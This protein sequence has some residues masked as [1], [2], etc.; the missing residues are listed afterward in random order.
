MN[1]GRRLLQAALLGL[2]ALAVQAQ[3]RA[4][5]PELLHPEGATAASDKP[6]APASAHAQHQMVAAAHPLAAAAGLQILRAGGSAL[7][8][9]V[10]TQLVLT[11]VEP[12]SSGIGG[13]AFLL[14]HDGQQTWAYDGRETAPAAAGEQLFL[15]AQGRPLD[16]ADAAVGGRAVGTPGVLRMLAL[17]HQRHGRL[18]WARL[19]GPA[20]ELAEQGFAM[21]PRLHALL[22]QTPQLRLDPH[23]AALYFD[24]QGQPLPV[25]TVLRNPELA[26][27]LRR[28]AAEGPDAFY[29]G[30]IAAA[31]VR[32]VREHPRNPG[33]LSLDDL[34]RYQAVERAPLCFEHRTASSSSD[35]GPPHAYRICGMPPPSSGTIAVGQILGLLQQARATTAAAAAGAREPD[36]PAALHLYAEASRLAFADRARYLAD[37]DHVALPGPQGQALLEPSYLARRAR[38]IDVQR[39]LPSAP[40]GDPTAAPQAL[41]PMP[42]QPE[43]GTSH[44]SIADRHGHVLAMTSSIEAAFGSRLMVNRGLG[45][46]GG[47]LL[48]NQ[49]TDFSFS[50]RD[51]NGQVVA[52]RVQ[53]NK[54]P[55]SSMTPVL[56][57]E[58]GSGRP[59]LSAG[60]PGGAYIIHYV[61]RLLLGVLDQGLPVAQAIA[62]PHVAAFD[63][64]VVLEQGRWPAATAQALRTLGHA[65]REQALP[66]GLQAIEIGPGWLRG[67][68]DPRREGLAL[69][70]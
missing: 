24:A 10:A 37:P 15:D 54:R 41:A 22:R 58:T 39:R 38:L 66:S 20:I 62:Q 17:A 32:A 61:S 36:T 34:R 13:G 6:P 40:A 33:L 25:G 29:G 45:L 28:I 55:R 9:A 5:L 14:Y 11:L 42:A 1:R 43:R 8:A 23:A 67:A 7:D 2:A 70:D 49:L 27:I 31:I 50:P 56:V 26:A 46:A 18:P 19:F 35:T 64:I 57:F 51:A 21:S 48:N 30:E 59:V 47:F 4:P 52:N 44:L 60:S 65:V 3:M 12:Q 16:F 68:A 63:D 69:G 53:P